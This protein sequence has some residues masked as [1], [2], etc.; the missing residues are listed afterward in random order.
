MREEDIHVCRFLWIS[1]V[2]RVARCNHRASHADAEHEIRYVYNVYLTANDL[3]DA[4]AKYQESKE[5]FT[6]MN[7]NLREFATNDTAISVSLPTDDQASFEGFKQL[8]IHW[9]LD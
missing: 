4:S 8:G 5:I 2:A 3:A 7:M 6:N 1:S 9:D